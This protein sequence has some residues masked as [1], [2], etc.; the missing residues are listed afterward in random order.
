MCTPSPR[1]RASNLNGLGWAC[2]A[3]ANLGMLGS[4][5]SGIPILCHSLCRL[6]PKKE[7]RLGIMWPPSLWHL[8]LLQAL[9]LAPG[10]LGR[11][12]T[13]ARPDSWASL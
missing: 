4:S 8:Q 9:W 12:L 11:V 2:L 6:P 3:Q 1:S 5:G 7:F 10:G 13:Q